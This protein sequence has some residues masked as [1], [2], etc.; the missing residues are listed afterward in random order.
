MLKDRRPDG[1]KKM[2]LEYFT[3]LTVILQLLLVVFCQL[4]NYHLCV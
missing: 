1:Y 2:H 3:M 4:G